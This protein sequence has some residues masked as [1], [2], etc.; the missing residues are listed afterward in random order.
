MSKEV[1]L[2]EH[3]SLLM[4]DIVTPSLDV[5]EVVLAL[6]GQPIRGKNRKEK[7][8]IMKGLESLGVSD[9]DKSKMHWRRLVPNAS[10]YLVVKE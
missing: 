10:Y 4:I 9:E 2:P 6:Y 8:D 5:H 7:K 3:L 1:K